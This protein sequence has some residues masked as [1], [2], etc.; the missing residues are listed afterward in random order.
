MKKSPQASRE[1]NPAAFVGSKICQEDPRRFLRR[2]VGISRMLPLAT[3]LR[4][5][6]TTLLPDF[7]NAVGFGAKTPR[8]SDSF[9]LG[10]L[11]CRRTAVTERGW[12]RQL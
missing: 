11:Y 1:S 9:I 4:Q 3:D 7:P 2:L 6:G 10:C 12:P 8:E 5:L